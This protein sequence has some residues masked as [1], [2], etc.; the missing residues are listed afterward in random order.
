MKL[1]SH[2]TSIALVAVAA[3]LGVWIWVDRAS[4]TDGERALRP[5]NVFG[6]FRR[7]ELSRVEIARGNDKLVLL[8]DVDRDADASWRIESPERGL[9]D[10]TAVDQLTSALEFATYV[11]KVD[12]KSAPTFDSPRATGALTMGSLVVRFELGGAAPVPEGASYMKVDRDVFVVSKETADRL[13]APWTTYKSRTIVPYLSLDLASLEIHGKDHD[14]RIERSGELTFK[15]AP[16]GLR[17]SRE[18]LDKLW[19]AL[20]EMRADSFETAV[21]PEPVLTI[22]M[23][24]KD[25]RPDAELAVGGPCADHPDDVLVVRK[26]P[27][28]L[29]AC[30]PKG[31]IEGLTLAASDLI[32][33]RLFFAHEDE[34]EELGMTGTAGGRIELARKG[35]GWH[36]R[37]PFDRD[38]VGDEVDSANTLLTAV[39]RAKGTGVAAFGT[40]ALAV[41]AHVRVH[42]GEM[43]GDELLDVGESPL[44]HWMVHRLADD[45]RLDVSQDVARKL[46][47]SKSALLGRDV[48]VPA[49]DPRDVTA[50]ALRCGT[51]QDLLRDGT[52]W[53]MTSP[54]GYTADQAAALDLAE[55]IAHLRADSWVADEDDGSFGFAA[56]SCTVTLTATRDGGSRK[57]TLTLGQDT[58][59]GVYAKLDASPVFLEP[60]TFRDSLARIL[61]DRSVVGVETAASKSIVISR[62]GAHV[63]LHR[64]ADKLEGPDA[65]L[66]VSIGS[67]VSALDALRADDVVHLGAPLADEGF[68]TPSL[69]VRA[70]EKT[71]RFG[72]D[73]L[74]KNQS[75]VLA[76]VSGVD[77]TF[78][79]ARERVLPLRNAL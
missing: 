12:A 28:P 46:L 7:D 9:A 10:P 24:P 48:V 58:Q 61:I 56:S 66:A 33:M 42:G 23:K 17:A 3:L 45:A 76:R 60:R 57:L 65:G 69:E 30:A 44:G 22:L 49:L 8:R 54:T 11:R 34:V 19:S 18:E 1:R 40:T 38:L 4:V 55:Q 13:L 26:A 2:W 43:A 59:A 35:S 6:V 20:S 32:D 36:A 41:R 68:G 77:A 16:S 29:S 73:V 78:A 75:M 74:R 31:I 5:K 15:V 37:S 70:G 53:K 64:V 14:V 62:P 39:V 25:G 63:E 71:I 72:R 79:V 51:A 27:T 50:I 52:A 47:P 67:I 21:V